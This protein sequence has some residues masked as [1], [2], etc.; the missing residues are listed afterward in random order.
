MRAQK[1]REEAERKQNLALE[2]Q[3]VIRDKQEGISRRI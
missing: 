1:L 3:R 2:E